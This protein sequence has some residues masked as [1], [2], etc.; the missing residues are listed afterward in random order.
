[1]PGDVEMAVDR[2]QKQRR[3]VIG[4]DDV[5]IRLEFHERLHS[6]EIP[7]ARGIHQRGELPFGIPSF[8]GRELRLFVV[9]LGLFVSLGFVFGLVL[10]LNCGLVFGASQSARRGVSLPATSVA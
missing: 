2:R 5:Q 7:I 10:C 4:V 6:L 1:M 8:L 3:T 9:L